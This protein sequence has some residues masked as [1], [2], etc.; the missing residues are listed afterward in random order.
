MAG[1]LQIDS[2]NDLRE[3]SCLR[4]LLADECIAQLPLLVSAQDDIARRERM[5]ATAPSPPIPDAET[6]SP[7]VLQPTPKARSNFTFPL[8][9][10]PVHPEPAPT[11][12]SGSTMH[13]MGDPP[14]S[15]STM[16]GVDGGQRAKR[17]RPPDHPPPTYSMPDSRPIGDPISDPP[18]SFIKSMLEHHD[19]TVSDEDL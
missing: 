6:R 2:S 18:G 1:L 7:P 14:S 12:P 5:I 16:R 8:V 17:P 15:D 4:R 3:L 10:G 13:R 19:G 9:G 11:M